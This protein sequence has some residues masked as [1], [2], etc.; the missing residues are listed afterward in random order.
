MF[1]NS[2]YISLAPSKGSPCR[3]FVV[4]GLLVMKS[5]YGNIHFVPH[6]SYILDVKEKGLK[7][8]SSIIL[9]TIMDIRKQATDTGQ[10]TVWNHL[11][12]RL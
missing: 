1:Y 3:G 4:H 6:R 11:K 7:T 10:E 2:Q 12:I 9:W 5:H 8:Y